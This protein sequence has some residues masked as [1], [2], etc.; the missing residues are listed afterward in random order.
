MGLFDQI[1]SAIDNPNLQASTGQL[2]GILNTVQSLSNAQGANPESTQT[3]V[4]VV[5]KHVRSALKSQ[6][7]GGQA[8]AL[9]DQYSGTGT[10]PEAVNTLFSEGQQQQMVQEISQRTGLDSK[11]I[12]GMLPMLVPL[13]LNLLNSGS[14][15][16][17][18]RQGGNPVLNS[19][20]D[21]NGD[22]DVDVSDA[23]RM[24]GQFLSKR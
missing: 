23:M 11:A 5:G 9:V 18:P 13:V 21:S 10:N 16:K 1:V 22:G 17:D 7:S 4:G 6:P 3:A 20:L 19:F 2:G 14:Q 12:A 8:Q 15:S 24:A